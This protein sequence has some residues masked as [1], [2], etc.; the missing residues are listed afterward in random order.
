MREGE[1]GRKEMRMEKGEM[2]KE[3]RKKKGEGEG[4]KG[5]GD[6]LLIRLIFRAT[7]SFMS[8]TLRAFLTNRRPI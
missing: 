2:R 4:K 1:K 5:C 8:V 3:G 7:E 6:K